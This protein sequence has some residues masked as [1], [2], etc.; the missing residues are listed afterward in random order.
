M[1]KLLA[2]AALLFSVQLH[3]E[4]FA[5]GHPRTTDNDRSAERKATVAVVERSA[6][7]C[8]PSPVNRAR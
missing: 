8:T 4:T 5:S 3:A 6:G 2:A 7:A 1:R